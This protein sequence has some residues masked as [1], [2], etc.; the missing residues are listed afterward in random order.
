MKTTNGGTSVKLST[1]QLT[2]ILDLHK[3]WLNNPD[4]GKQADLSGVDLSWA[5]L[6]GANLSWVNLSRANLSRANLKGA[7]LFEANLKGANLKGAKR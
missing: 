6:S 4:T 2:E 7:N 1:D 5:D 3:K